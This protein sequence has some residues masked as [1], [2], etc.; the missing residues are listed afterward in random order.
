[1]PPADP[2]SCVTLPL[3]DADATARL[4]ALLARAVRAGDTILLSGE[5]GAGKSHLARALIAA[6]RA[7]AGEPPED[8]PSPSY[9]LVQTYRAGATEIWHIDL[10]RLGDPGEV[11]E[12]GLSEALGEAICLV[13][14]PERLPPHLVPAEASTIALSPQGEGRLAR[15][16]LRGGL[17]RRLG[18]ILRA[19]ADA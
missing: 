4:G 15:L 9:T 1:M 2:P 11:A 19:P 6:L 10:Y 14:W 12:L 18:S 7:A 13:E 5:I 16:V 8:I 3:P 17:A